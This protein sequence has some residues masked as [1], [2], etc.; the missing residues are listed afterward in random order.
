MSLSQ[1]SSSGRSLIPGCI[2][3]DA[4]FRASWIPASLLRTEQCL[5]EMGQQQNPRFARLRSVPAPAAHSATPSHSEDKAAA[6][7]AQLCLLPAWLTCLQA[8]LLDRHSQSIDVPRWLRS[9]SWLPLQTA[10]LDS[11]VFWPCLWSLSANSF[12]QATEEDQ[13][14]DSPRSRGQAENSCSHSGQGRSMSACKCEARTGAARSKSKQAPPYQLFPPLRSGSLPST[15][16]GFSQNAFHSSR[17]QAPFF[18]F[19]F[20]K[21]LARRA[22]RLAR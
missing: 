17:V 13:E 5:M 14:T 16:A 8:A 9:K 4:L 10:S 12:H 15:Q 2:L 18:F 1:A 19:F 20:A 11:Q 6:P 3:A 7:S 21:H 22:G